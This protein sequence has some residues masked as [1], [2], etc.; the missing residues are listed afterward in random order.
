MTIPTANVSMLSN[1]VA[2]CQPLCVLAH[3]EG[4]SGIYLLSC[5]V[6]MPRSFGMPLKYEMSR[7][8]REVQVTRLLRAAQML[9]TTS[10]DGVFWRPSFGS[11]DTRTL[12]IFVAVRTKKKNAHKTLF[13]TN[14]LYYFIFF[15]LAEHWNRSGGACHPLPMWSLLG[16]CLARF[17]SRP[18][19]GLS[20]TSLLVSS[21]SSRTGS[22]LSCSVTTPLSTD[23]HWHRAANIG[24]FSGVPSR[25]RFLLSHQRRRHIISMTHFCTKLHYNHFYGI[26]IRNVLRSLRVHRNQSIKF[27]SQ[28]KTISDV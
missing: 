3:T 6:L 22:I 1:P 8:A 4:W 7:A 21:R 15:S 10:L 18:V 11:L 20:S 26:M 24:P 27:R 17:L 5:N 19:R 12:T 16:Q 25:R 28:I 13:L 2:L 14:T 23:G 9:T